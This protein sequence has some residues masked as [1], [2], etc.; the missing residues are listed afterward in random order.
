MPFIG[1]VMFF[2]IFLELGMNLNFPCS[3]LPL[4]VVGA[5]HELIPHPFN[6]DDITPQESTSFIYPS[7][8]IETDPEQSEI[9]G[10]GKPFVKE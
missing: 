8:C 5:D 7:C 10:V 1:A 9:A 6:A 4:G 2:Q 3:L